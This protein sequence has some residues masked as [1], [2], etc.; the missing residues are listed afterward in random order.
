MRYLW[1]VET[2]DGTR[3]NYGSLS[4]SN[5][6]SI[7]DLL[8]KRTTEKRSETDSARYIFDFAPY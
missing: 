6:V 3:T 8:S 1:S 4:S 2:V 5:S 7:S